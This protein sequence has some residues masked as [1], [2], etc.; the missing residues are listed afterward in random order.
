L[1]KSPEIDRVK[2]TRIKVMGC[3]LKRRIKACRMLLRNPAR[4][5]QFEERSDGKI[6]LRLSTE[7]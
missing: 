3:I 6:M 7:K 1:Y 2:F 5:V 4:K